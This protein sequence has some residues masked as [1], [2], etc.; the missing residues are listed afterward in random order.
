MDLLILTAQQ[1]QE[2]LLFTQQVDGDFE[3]SVLIKQG[4]GYGYNGF[5]L[6]DWNQDERVDLLMVNGN[7]ME[8]RNAPIKNYHGIRIPQKTPDRPFEEALI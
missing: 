8:I 6:V 4:A 7:N 2:L 5:E 3:R 1:H